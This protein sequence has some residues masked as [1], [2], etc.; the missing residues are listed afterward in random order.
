M[1]RDSRAADPS[2]AR[3]RFRS[4]IGYASL[5]LLI[6]L[7][8][9]G[10]RGFRDLGLVREREAE[11]EAAIER[12]QDEIQQL[13]TQVERL[14]DDPVLLERLARQELGMTRPGEVVVIFD[15]ED[16]RL[17]STATPPPA[18]PSSDR[19]APASP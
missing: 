2:P 5:L 9:A 8:I 12:T 7:V 15:R 3:S 1:T 14:R 10:F 4:A 11:L 18:E 16:E 19:P 17:D 6:F 13:E